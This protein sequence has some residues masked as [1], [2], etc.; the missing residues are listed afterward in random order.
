MNNN[1]VLLTGV[2]GYIGRNL[3]RFFISMGW[4][5][6]AIIR[7]SSNR[8]SLGDIQKKL[9]LHIFDGEM[10]TLCN[11]LSSH[12]DTVIHTASLFVAEH[13]SEDIGALVSSNILFGTQLLEAMV[14]NEIYQL[15]N[16]G[17]SWQHYNN[18]TYEPVCLY[19]ATKQAFDDILH[20]YAKATPLKAI[21]LKL[22]DTYGPNDP[23]KKM[24][25]MLNQ[26]AKTNQTLQMSQG[27]QLVDF[28]YIDDVVLAYLQAVKLLADTHISLQ[29]FAVSSGLPIRLRELVEKYEN[30]IGRKLPIVWG[31]RPYRNRE[32]MIPWN[33][34]MRLPGWSP[35]IGLE[36]GIRKMLNLD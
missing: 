3:A 21:T 26:L 16:T 25:P 23:R 27:E 24:F 15:V 5:V 36:S 18:A 13:K 29:D 30:I 4:K 34:G 6:H 35:Q 22:F 9:I 7:P 14:K 12:P 31:G 32:V 10:A 8:Y 11:I 19:A 28:V 20:Y 1:T 33:T 17:T 2:T